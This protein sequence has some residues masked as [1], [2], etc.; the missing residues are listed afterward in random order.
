PDCRIV[1][2]DN[3]PLVLVHA[4]A[5][6]TSAAQGATDYLHADLRDPVDV[7]AGAARTLDLTKPV[8]ITILGV[9]WHIID[10]AEARA[11]IERLMAPLPSGSYIAIAHPTL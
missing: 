1:Y 5:L 7:L 4:Q 9:L 10:D 6:L 2:V 11:I 3:D 8:A